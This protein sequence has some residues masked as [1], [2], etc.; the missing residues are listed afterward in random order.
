MFGDKSIDE[1]IYRHIGIEQLRNGLT[2]RGQYVGPTCSPTTCF[3]NT[4]ACARDVQQDVIHLHQTRTH[5]RKTSSGFL[6]LLHQCKSRNIYYYLIDRFKRCTEPEM[7]QLGLDVNL[8]ALHTLVLTKDDQSFVTSLYSCS[9]HP[10][11]SSSCGWH[12]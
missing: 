12:C 5:I 7:Q 9:Y 8:V 1:E 6:C 2:V 3:P 10:E 11:S 4:V